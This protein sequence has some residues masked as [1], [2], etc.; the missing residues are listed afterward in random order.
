MLCAV[1]LLCAVHP[2]QLAAP[3]VVVAV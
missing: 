3:P 2:H 1:H